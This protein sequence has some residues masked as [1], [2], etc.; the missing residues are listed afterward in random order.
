MSNHNTYL[1]IIVFFIRA[2]K[3]HTQLELTLLSYFFRKMELLEAK[4]QNA[5]ESGGRVWSQFLAAESVQGLQ[6]TYV[7]MISGDIQ[8]NSCSTGKNKIHWARCV[9]SI[10]LAYNISILL[11]SK[12][13]LPPRT[14]ISH[15]VTKL[16][17]VILLDF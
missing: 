14:C 7:M 9:K 6:F 12:L 1:L 3:L 2:Q 17:R 10:Y 13:H 15:T 11:V 5:E 4:L 16:N 8:S